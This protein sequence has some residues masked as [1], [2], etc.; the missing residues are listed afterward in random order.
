MAKA[1]HVGKGAR[2]GFTLVE[3]LVVITIIGILMGLLIPA[4]NAARETARRNQ[5]STQ[6]NNLAK[7]AIQYEMAKKQFPGWVNDFGFFAAGTGAFDPSD[8]ELTGATYAAHKKLGSWVVSLLPSL[9]AQPTYEVWTQDKYPVI[10]TTGSQRFTTN[11]A[12]SLAI[13]QC[14]SSTTL[15]GEFARNSYIAN[16]GMWNYTT[17]STPAQVQRDTANTPTIATAN[18]VAVTDTMSMAKDNG[19]F[20][21]KYAGTTG[22]AVGPAVRLD[23][24]KDG[25]GNTVLFSENLQAVPW[26]QLHPVESSAT[27]A[28]L[29]ATGN[30]EVGFPTLSRLTQ[31]F[32]WHYEDPN[33]YNGAPVVSTTQ[34]RL[35]NSA[36]NGEDKF[37]T[38]MEGG[39][40]ASVARPSSAH[41]DG[42]NMGFAD[43]ASKFIADSIDYRVYQALMTPRGKSSLV[44]F[45]E[46]VLQGEA[47]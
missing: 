3:L 18:T 12:P 26:S 40:A 42:V 16:N 19:V 10:V 28:L 37:I 22:A 47:L 1:N 30:T 39:N 38:R 13:M 23:D 11:A 24:F 4:V 32:V 43:G 2:G 29:P 34:A 5:C 15:E 31:G 35:I 21:N 17:G 44:P 8:P 27:N 20:N 33:Q 46:Y 9:D 25:Q 41:N 45:R 7:A 36:H 14:P 6:I